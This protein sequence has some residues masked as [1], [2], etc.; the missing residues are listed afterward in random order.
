MKR[1]ISIFVLLMLIITPTISQVSAWNTIY[2]TMENKYPSLTQKIDKLFVEVEDRL[3]TYKDLELH[4]QIYNRIIQNVWTYEK[5]LSNKLSADSEIYK[6]ISIILEY[7]KVKA[8]DKT[9]E[10]EANNLINLNE[11]FEDV[12]KE[13]V[14]ESQKVYNIES[15]WEKVKYTQDKTIS[16]WE[17]RIDS[18]EKKIPLEF[19]LILKSNIWPISVSDVKIKTQNWNLV[20]E[21]FQDKKTNKNEVEL[22][23]YY[24]YI[25][26]LD[27]SKILY[28]EQWVYYIE[29]K[30]NAEN[31]KIPQD[32][33]WKISVSIE[34]K[35]VE[36]FISKQN[37]KPETTTQ[38]NELLITSFQVESKQNN[39]NYQPNSKTT[40]WEFSLQFSEN[41]KGIEYP[42]KIETL[43]SSKINSFQIKNII[44]KNKNGKIIAEWILS[45]S[46]N[47]N[48]L[49]ESK[50]K[51]NSNEKQE[52]EDEWKLYLESWTYYIEWE[53]LTKENTTWR[54]DT[55]LKIT[56]LNWLISKKTSK[57]TI[58]LS[59]NP[60]TIK[61]TETT[62][63]LNTE[64]TLISFFRYLNQKDFE[65]AVELF[66]TDNREQIN[67]FTSKEDRNLKEVVLRDYCEATGTCLEIKIIWVEETTEDNEY[68]FKVQF[69]NKDGSIFVQWPCCGAML[70]SDKFDFTVKKIDWKFKVTTPP[71]YRP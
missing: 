28:L 38:L 55:S 10:I 22:M 50:F 53:I 26:T 13:T 58:S 33:K 41:Q 7:I 20:W 1:I 2:E 17:F 36:W 32:D 61:K 70:S 44:L 71:L 62:E 31:P 25:E 64:E 3:S 47:W 16:L 52:S 24:P 4:K 21:W 27:E 37:L 29:W 42:L 12:E 57:P 34:T 23:L 63:N 65:K 15:L 68:I 67:A 43:L 56:W 39:I 49:N 45:D 40:F 8:E 18:S 5:K 54:I 59:L 66:E 51:F 9:T 11:I 46:T 19:K 60:I 14:T 35:W 48:T 69:L 30:I 6:E